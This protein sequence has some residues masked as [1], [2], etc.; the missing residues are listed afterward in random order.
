MSLPQLNNNIYNC[1]FYVFQLVLNRLRMRKHP[2]A[3]RF[4]NFEDNFEILN[5]RK[6]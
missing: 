2:I 3:G 4:W 5:S 6:R 1:V